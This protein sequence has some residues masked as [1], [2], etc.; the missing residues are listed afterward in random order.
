MASKE[1]KLAQTIIKL[2][3]DKKAIESI[4]DERD[5]GDVGPKID[6]FLAFCT[7]ENKEAKLA[8]ERM[9]KAYIKILKGILD[10]GRFFSGAE[11]KQDKYY[12]STWTKEKSAEKT[13]KS[14]LVEDA[15]RRIANKLKRR[16]RLSLLFT[17][18]ASL[19]VFTGYIQNKVE[20][21]SGDRNYYGGL[22]GTAAL[23]SY[24]LKQAI[25]LGWRHTGI[26]KHWQAFKAVAEQIQKLDML[27]KDIMLLDEYAR[28]G[29]KPTKHEES[30][31]EGDENLVED[32]G[33]SPRREL[34]EVKLRVD[35]LADAYA[36][37]SGEEKDQQQPSESTPLLQD[38]PGEVALHTLPDGEPTTPK[39]K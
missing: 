23:L 25:S 20:P 34:Q 4:K 3:K 36:V 6:E 9:V 1:A 39:P 33:Y 19:F 28:S 5:R 35:L 7:E 31:Q 10:S 11:D 14:F 8:A 30:M 38:S 16:I 18:D 27:F 24:V 22:I 2:L 13:K 12:S 29:A 26:K 32:A 21:G 17:I 37:A 15:E